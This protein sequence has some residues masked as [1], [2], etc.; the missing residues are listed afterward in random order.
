MNS[1]NINNIDTAKYLNINDIGF[2]ILLLIFTPPLHL[3]NIN[4]I[5]HLS[6]HP[7][8]VTLN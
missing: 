1:I 3:L 5:L 6:Y 7:I 2:S 8:Q 4:S